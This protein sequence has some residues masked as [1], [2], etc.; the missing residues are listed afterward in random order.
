M[1]SLTVVDLLVVSF[2]SFI[3]Y[4]EQTMNIIIYPNANPKTNTKPNSPYNVMR[5]MV[6]SKK[7][8]FPAIWG[9]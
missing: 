3:I 9:I 1:P 5:F 2:S 7:A 4:G 6:Q 8:S